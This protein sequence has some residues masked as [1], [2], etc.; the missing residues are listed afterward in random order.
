MSLLSFSQSL[1]PS[2]HLINN[3]T[4]GCFTFDQMR[5]IAKY[6]TNSVYC[7][8]LLN[9]CNEKVKLYDQDVAAQQMQIVFLEE[10]VNKYKMIDQNNI[11]IIENKDIIIGD[12]KKKLRKCKVRAGFTIIGVGLLGYLIGNQ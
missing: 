11:K 8:S 3:D 10:E 6:M 12:Y 4:L 9:E 5:S 7:D 2:I 1:K